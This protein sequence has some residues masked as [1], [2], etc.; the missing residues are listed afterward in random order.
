VTVPIAAQEVLRELGV[1]EPSEINVDAT[2]WSLGA[3]V[4]YRP[5]D[6]CEARI[7][8]NGDQAIINRQQ[9]EFSAAK[10]IFRRPRTRS[11]EIPPWSNSCLP[12]RRNRA[13]R[14]KLPDV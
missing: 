4:K 10:K 1:T 7:T 6:S 8:G 14:S 5:T 3:R 11:L 9:Q 12:F 2:A 13:C